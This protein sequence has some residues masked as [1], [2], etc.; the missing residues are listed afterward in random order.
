MVTRPCCRYLREIMLPEFKERV[1]NAT[2]EGLVELERCD[3]AAAL[4]RYEC[5]RKLF[6]GS[7]WWSR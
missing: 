6:V 3:M 4:S 1:A 2:H 7:V 5:C